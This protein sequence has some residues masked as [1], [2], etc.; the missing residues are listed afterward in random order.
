MTASNGVAR[1]DA[2]GHAGPGLRGREGAHGAHGH[3]LGHEAHRGVAGAEAGED[4]RRHPASLPDCGVCRNEV[5]R[6]GLE[7]RAAAQAGRLPPSA[8]ACAWLRV[9]AARTARMSHGAER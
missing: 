8:R 6:G 9:V 7:E 3:A 2:V 1:E 5:T 4:S